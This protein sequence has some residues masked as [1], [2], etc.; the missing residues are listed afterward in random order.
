MNFECKR[1]GMST[2]DVVIVIAVFWTL[3]MAANIFFA[4]V[5]LCAWNILASAAGWV[6]ITIGWGTIIATMLFIWLLRSIF[7]R[8]GSA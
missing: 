2:R 1:V 5:S 4:W 8:K 3:S 6:T 7:G